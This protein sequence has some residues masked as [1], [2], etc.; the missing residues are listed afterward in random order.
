MAGRVLTM[1]G[2][3]PGMPE[4]RIWMR[5]VVWFAVV[6]VEVEGFEA[7]VAG[8]GWEGGAWPNLANFSF[9]A[10]KLVHLTD[11]LKRSSCDNTVL[12]GCENRDI[13]LLL[14]GP[15]VRLNLL[16]NLLLGF[17]LL[18][19]QSLVLLNLSQLFLIFSLLNQCRRILIP[20]ASN[21]LL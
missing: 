17:H 14:P 11:C 5:A 1:L 2:G 7:A 15:F 19:F 13:Y 18:P 20:L 16:L 21:Q 9:S 3:A 12:G 6:V 10:Y 8:A 4:G